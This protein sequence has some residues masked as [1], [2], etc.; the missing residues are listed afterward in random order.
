[1]PVHAGRRAEE[2]GE[3]SRTFRHHGLKAVMVP[4]STKVLN[5]I[6]ALNAGTASET[7]TREGDL[8]ETLELFF[9]RGLLQGK[10]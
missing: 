8:L 2:M 9:Q 4:A 3:L 5:S 7:G 10:G 6:A 1:M